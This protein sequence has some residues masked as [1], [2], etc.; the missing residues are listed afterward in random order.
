MRPLLNGHHEPKHLLHDPKSRFVLDI[1][2]DQ[3]LHCDVVIHVCFNVPCLETLATL[4]AER[5]ARGP[6]DEQ[7]HRLLLQLRSLTAFIA[8]LTAQEAGCLTRDLILKGLE[9][10]AEP[11]CTNVRGEELTVLGIY[12]GCGVDVEVQPQRLPNRKSSHAAA[13][14]TVLAHVGDSE[15]AEYLQP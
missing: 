12:V 9:N 3:R 14:D 8:C 6:C 5:V 1:H 13:T 7:V 15:Y 10:M 2:V 4:D 11:V